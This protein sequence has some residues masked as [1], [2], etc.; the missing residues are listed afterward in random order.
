MYA[1]KSN[2]IIKGTKDGL[3]FYLNDSCAY[4]ELLAELQDKLQ[5]HP[6]FLDG[7]LMRVTIHLGHRYLSD[8]QRNELRDLI[9]AQ[10]NL[11]VD[12]MESLVVL[13]EEMEQAR[14]E[15]GIQVVYKTVRS[16]QVVEA[17]GHLLVL[18]DVNP[19]GCVK[20]VGNIF[21][22]GALRGMA[23][24]GVHGNRGAII[25]ASVLCPTQLRIASVVGRPPDEAENKGREFAHVNGDQI[26][27][28]KLQQLVHIR[29][30]LKALCVS[31]VNRPS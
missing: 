16:G 5:D 1:T 29:P 3:V 31:M 25:A 13:K 6:Q 20:A 19:G 2:V 24:A 26:A 22:L 21:V 7:P 12:K 14:T 4:E 23:H 27:I 28:A 9:R 8:E 15:T 30:E 18:G 10:G 11:I 17:P